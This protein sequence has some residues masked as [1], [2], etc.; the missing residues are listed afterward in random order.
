MMSIL[1]GARVSIAS[2]VEVHHHCERVALVSVLVHHDTASAGGP[3]LGTSGDLDGSDRANYMW[4]AVWDHVS[5]RHSNSKPPLDGAKLRRGIFAKK[6]K[7]I[8]FILLS[9]DRFSHLF[10][11]LSY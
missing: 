6:I 8:Y 3:M 7:T 2:L 4:E 5:E 11:L 1:V 10:F 9:Y